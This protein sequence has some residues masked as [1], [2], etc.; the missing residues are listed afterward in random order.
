M[1]CCYVNATSVSQF[2]AYICFL[3]FL[4]TQPSV[5]VVAVIIILYDCIFIRMWFQFLI[6][7]TR[8]QIGVV[9]F[10]SWI[11]IS[12]FSPEMLV[13]AFKIHFRSDE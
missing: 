10:L 2:L 8:Y 5:Q 6:F 1:S 9:L 7:F 11:Q 13:C 12:N 4:L 3:Y